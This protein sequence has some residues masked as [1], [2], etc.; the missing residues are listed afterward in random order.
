MLKPVRLGCLV[1]CA[2]FSSLASTAQQIPPSA[3]TFVNS[4]A[5]TSNYGNLGFLTVGSGENTYIQFN[6]SN[7]PAGSVVTKATLRL[8]VDSVTTGGQFDVYEV[9]P[10]TP[11]TES[12]VN[13]NIAPELGTAASPSNPITV[14]GGSLNDFVLVDIT[15]IAQGW[16]N[17]P[18]SNTG[19]A[20]VLNGTTGEFFFDSKEGTATSHEPELEIQLQG[21]A[22]PTGPRGPA[23]P[24]GNT[25][26]AGPLGPAGPTGAMGATGATGATGSKGATGPTGPQ[27]PLGSTGSAGPPGPTG[28]RGATGANGSTGATGA[29]GATGVAGPTGPRGGIG[30]TGATGAVGPIGPAGAK[31]ATGPTGAQGPTGST[32][33]TGAQGIQGVPGTPGIQGPSGTNGT[34]GTGFNFTGPFVE[35]NTYQPYD[36]ATYNGSTYEATVAIAANGATPDQSN[37]AWTLMAAAGAPGAAGTP[38]AAGPI[39]PAGATGASGADGTNG[40]NGTN[41][42]GFNFT[43]P[44]VEANAYQPYDVVTYNGS[45]YE[46]TVAIA[47]NGVTPDQNSAWTL[48]AAAGAPGAAGAT[49]AAGTPGA[50]GAPG[51]TGATGPTGPAGTDADTNSRMIFPSFFPG[52]LSGTWTGGQVTIDQPITIL[53]IAVTAKTPTGASCPSAVFRFTDGTKGEDLVLAP[54]VYWSDSG[55]I[56]MSFAAGATLQSI[57]RTG[58]TCAANTGADANLLV[59]YKMAAGDA[60]TCGSGALCGTYCETTSL[61]PSN[62]GSC[63]TACASG[64]PCVSGTCGTANGTS[65]TS[66]SSCQSGF[67]SSGV[68]AVNPC[69]GQPAGTTCG[70]TSCSGKSCTVFQCD[71]SGVCQQSTT[72]CAGGGLEVCGTACVD[73]SKDVNNC[74]A[75][76]TVCSS[77]HDTPSCVSGACS[78]ASCAAGYANCNGSAADG[79]EVNTQSD[80]NNCGG[81]GIACTTGQTCNSGACVSTQ[82]PAGSACTANTQCLSDVCGVAGTGTCCT[83][84]CATGSV[85]GANACSATGACV[86]APSGTTCDLGGTCNGAGTCQACTSGCGIGVACTS[87]TNCASNAC[88]ASTNLCVSSQ[89]ADNRT[90]GLETDVDCGGGTCAACA[91]G[92]SC[93]VDTDCTSNACDANSLKCVSSQC[94]DNRKD[95]AETDVDCGGGTCPTCAVGNNCQLDTDCTSNACDANSLKCVSNQCA[96]HRKDGQESDVDCGGPVCNSC[97]TGQH[98]NSSLDCVSGHACLSGVCN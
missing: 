44:F 82:L 23:G 26:P 83:T 33:A 32:G 22:G 96:D 77:N 16:I 56:A 87:D 11:W 36:V 34:N 93:H 61:D 66:N 37:P 54:G 78:V 59:E 81:C 46:A 51:A 86:Y 74:G 5:P 35:A 72:S 15:Q 57:L 27:G 38:G 73:T 13:F 40:T 39:G 79:C 8:F 53:R 65:C 47:A 64:D 1:L 18:S 84:A 10:S 68:C 50:P 76:G 67:C 21:V 95:G 29:T 14:S 91:V 60:D 42:T 70:S 41:G 19:I 98:C 75:C 97:Q 94:I 52:N 43:G 62:C 25:G 80:A 12:T 89:C 90:D 63:G 3:D 4:T 2:L 85:C 71:G 58:S 20:V 6:L 49:G 92:K 24:P 28:A 30:L 69:I 9:S 55:P 17:T 31:G 88:S 48:M 45:T 7:V